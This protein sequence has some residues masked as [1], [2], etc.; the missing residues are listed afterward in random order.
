MSN[1]GANPNPDLDK[2]FQVA[3]G[4]RFAPMEKL[5]VD[6][7]NTETNLKVYHL[8]QKIGSTRLDVLVD[9]ALLPQ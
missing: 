2:I 6:E 5:K 1:F 8:V 4:Y 3:F 9:P 7:F